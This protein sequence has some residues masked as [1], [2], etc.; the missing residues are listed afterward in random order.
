MDASPSVAYFEGRFCPIDEARISITSFVVNYGLGAFA[1]I[2]AYWNDTDQQLLLF[3]SADHF[4]RLAYAAAVLRCA[5]LPDTDELVAIA[6]RLLQ[7][8]ACRE[9]SYLRV[10]L[11]KGAGGIG[12]R[13]HDVPDEI[14]MYVLPLG[15]LAEPGRGLDF[16]TSA[17]RRIADNA[18]PARGKICGAYVN[19]GLAKT[20]AMLAGYDEPLLL[21][22]S[23][24][25]AQGASANI[26]LVKGGELCTP[27]V[28]NDILEGITRNTIIELATRRLGYSVLERPIDRS[29]LFGADEIFCCGTG[30]E[31]TPIRSVDGRQVAI[32]PPGPMTSAIKKLYEQVVRGCI[33]DLREKWCCPVY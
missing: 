13:L 26:F 7:A 33:L 19:A 24:H 31:V 5:G 1:G 32:D 30:W 3:R 6:I 25:V 28:Y 27:P 21:D 11:Y 17:W 16:G 15:R 18:I 29:E 10:I 12:A 9:D 23:G 4:R 14:A 20:D 22:D 2:R 8:N